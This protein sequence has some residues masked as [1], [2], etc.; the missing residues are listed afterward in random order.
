MLE[1]VADLAAQLFVEQLAVEVDRAA[2]D[3]RTARDGVQKC[4]LARTCISTDGKK[5]LTYIFSI[6]CVSFLIPEGPMT[7]KISPGCT[8]PDTSLSSARL[9]TETD[10]PVK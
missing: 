1:D 8:T 3:G 10:S 5:M 2:L 6:Y 9:P 4:R 7:A